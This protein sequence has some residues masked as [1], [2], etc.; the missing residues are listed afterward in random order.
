MHYMPAARNT[1]DGTRVASLAQLAFAAVLENSADLELYRIMHEA[2]RVQ[3][4]RIEMAV[5]LPD[6]QMTASLTG[7]GLAASRAK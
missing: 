6:A 2:G 7:R 5:D 4:H 1:T 3:R